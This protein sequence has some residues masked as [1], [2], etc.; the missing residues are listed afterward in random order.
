M[1]KIKF[2]FLLILFA[3]TNYVKTQQYFFKNYSAESG[4]PFVQV[5]CLFQDHYGYLWSGGYG[6]LSRFDGKTFKNFTKKDGL[7]DNYV[8]A[9]CEDDSN[10]LYIATNKGINVF[11]NSCPLTKKQ[12]INLNGLAV[13]A[14]K[15]A[16]NNLLYVGTNKGL[17]KLEKNKI[18][19]IVQIGKRKINCIYK[20]IN[21][22]I[23]IGTDNG[24]FVIRE[25]II[26]NYTILNGL[27]SNHI[28]CISNI[29]NNIVIGTTKGLTVLNSNFQNP[30]TYKIE[31]GL[32]DENIKT[33]LYDDEK[34][35]IGSNTGLIYLK[36]NQFYFTDIYNDNNS[37]YIRCL[38]K[39]KENNIWIGTHTGIFKYRDNSFVS[40]D[41][42]SGP[43]NAFVYG[44]TKDKQNSLW[45]C[46]EN[47]GIYSYSNSYFK[48]YGLS[49]GLVSNV[50]RSVVKIDSSKLLFGFDNGLM[51][52][53]NNKFKKI[54]IDLG[55]KGPF[56]FSYKAK[57]A[58]IY[59]G[60]YNG[61]LKLIFSKNTIQSHLY[62]YSTKDGFNAYG[63]A[64]D[65]SGKLWIG[66]YGY[67]M[68]TILNDSIKNINKEMNTSEE[69]FFSN[70]I[71][72]NTL[73]AGTLSG[74]A[75]YDINTKKLKYITEA[76]GLNSD[77]IYSLKITR[78]KKYL[79]IGTN[80]GI[81]TLNLDK[82]FNSNKIEIKSYGKE[83][84][85]TG[86]E[87]NSGGI[88]E[89]TNGAVWFGTV[90]GVV[91][92]DPFSIKT[93]TLQNTTLIQQ[94]Q[95]NSIDTIVKSGVKLPY[96]YNNITFQY[97][98]ICLTNPLKV[99][100]IKKLEGLD[101]NWSLPSD[102]DYSKYI[103]LPA[104]K[105]IFKV[106]SS[107]NEGQ[108]NDYETAFEFEIKKPF[109]LTYW[110]FII[111]ILFLTIIVI[112]IF[113]IRVARIKKIQKLDFERKVEMSK[114][115]LK[116]LRSQMNPHFVFNSLN[117]IQHYIYSNESTEAIK[118][119]NKFARLVRIIL[120][121]SEKPTVTIEED[122]EALKLYLE[123]E[124]MRFEGKFEYEIIVDKNVDTDY[125]I[126]PPLLMQ[127][128][129]ENAILHGLNPL[130]YKGK[131]TIQL[132]VKE[133][134]LVCTIIDNGIGREKARAITHSIPGKKH[135]SFGMKI[136]E[137]RLRILNELNNSTLS[138]N[139]IDLKDNKGNPTGTKVDLFVPLNS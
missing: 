28:N 129:V 63:F 72:Y 48:R 61:I 59:V 114:V 81:N 24:L 104:G 107:N 17:Y 12:S 119:L 134:I 133:N 19:H 7:T 23:Y 123:L 83:E 67:G 37:N 93:N 91:K 45:F 44:I 135:K 125:D 75:V 98:G 86:V 89:E 34:L 70:E 118:Y 57:D 22:E 36:D 115:E 58:S 25:N 13:T 94:I 33:L 39:G 87:C 51:L 16:N 109:Y 46:T 116:A 14:I 29:K 15:N 71:I 73:F 131:L 77:L 69:N 100:Y 79:W 40:F 56:D 68:F 2:L 35:W 64:E 65:N 5:F 110:F 137:D 52:Y 111:C 43:G 26:K 121:N 96:S 1:K 47:N 21:N 38:I 95:L 76:D 6:G 9:I 50:C 101:K 122:L 102:E 32:I 127:P 139:I 42:Y 112:V 82:Y 92:H 113:Q 74:L 18:I 138:V 20:H 31:N 124:Q 78:N 27:A 11:K 88:Y 117:S 103:N 132:T 85:F 80:Q 126:M 49:D 130:N 41:K 105:Y 90:S 62:K 8:N 128:Y 10:Y 54:N 55:V 53:E 120:N 60:C 3:F 99:K 30:V 66:T 4:L 106:K 84:G 97:R 108:W 136:T